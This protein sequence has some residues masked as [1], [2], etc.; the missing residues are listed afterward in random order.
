MNKNV[1]LVYFSAT[2]TTSKIVKAIGSDLGSSFI[3]HNI[4]LPQA[5]E[6]PLS[7]THQ[8]LVVVGV[9]VYAGR[10]PAFLVDYFTEMKGENTPVICIV[11]YG[12]RHYDD[13][14]LELKELLE[15]NGF[16]PVA[17]GAFIGEHSNTRKVATGRP[18]SRDA[19]E[20][21]KFANQLKT[22]LE[23]ENRDDKPPSLT[24]YG[25]HPYKE[26]KPMP[27]MTPDTNDNCTQCGICAATCPMG[28]IDFEDFITVDETLCIH[29]SSCV[30]RCPVDAKH[31]HHE[32]FQ[33]FT[34]ML[35]DKCS[36]QRREPE[37]FL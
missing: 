36:N 3:D 28:A 25:N 30:K 37:F 13:A 9:P 7:F 31:I 20:A 18:D 29:C 22:K 10:V 1:H 23:K 12:N 32:I 6:N 16:L 14:L 4:T 15:E 19:K 24:V 21:I 11:L 2:D 34:Q 5:R 26:R 33:N 27:P 8:D 35:I 17:G